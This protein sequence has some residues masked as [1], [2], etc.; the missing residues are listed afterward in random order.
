[1][2]RLVIDVSRDDAPDRIINA[3]I[4]A[5]GSIDY[6]INNAGIAIGGAFEEL[7]DEQWDLIMG[8]NVRSM[9]RI[10]RAAVPHLKK[11]S[12]PRIINLGSIMSDMAGPNLS[13]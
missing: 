7:T 4:E 11:S 9:F 8:V 12:S 6:L 13:I 10:S 5:F 2:A 1:M 3:A